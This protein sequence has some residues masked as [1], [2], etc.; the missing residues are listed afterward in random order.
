MRIGYRYEVGEVL[1][2]DFGVSGIAVF[3]LSSELA[4][5]RAKIG[6]ILTI[7]FMPEYSRAE[8]EDILR[9][10]GANLTVGELM[11]GTYHTKVQ[12]RIIAAANCDPTEPAQAKI[13][14]LANVIKNYKLEIE[15]LGDVSLAQVMSGGLDPR[16][17]DESLMSMHVKNAYAIGEALDIDG[18]CGGYNLQWAW[19]SAMT[20][21]R[22]I[23]RNV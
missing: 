1:F 10:R 12:E 21:A 14:A 13:G 18:D 5:D 11:L 15:G 17:F 22:S 23:M 4:R 8:V 19:T 3:N 2:K 20:A 7:D 9:K 16:E 6:D